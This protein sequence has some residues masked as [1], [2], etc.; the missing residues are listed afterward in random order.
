MK[1]NYLKLVYTFHCRHTPRAFAFQLIFS[2]SLL[3]ITIV[4]QKIAYLNILHKN[5]CFFNND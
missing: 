3:L 1:T 4:S 2:A 5:L